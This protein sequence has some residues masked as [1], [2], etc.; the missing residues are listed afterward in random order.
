LDQ[1]ELEGLV[2]AGEAMEGQVP[3]VPEEAEEEPLKLSEEAPD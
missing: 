3:D 1:G 2:V